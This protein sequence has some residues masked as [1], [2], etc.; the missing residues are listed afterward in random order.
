[1]TPIRR[2]DGGQTAIMQRQMADE[3][4]EGGAMMYGWL[5]HALCSSAKI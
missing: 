3:D 1:V 5:F 4:D 2:H